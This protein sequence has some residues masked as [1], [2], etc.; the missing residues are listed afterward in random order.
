MTKKCDI[1]VNGVSSKL[2]LINLVSSFIQLYFHA[3]NSMQV[4]FYCLMHIM[5]SMW[6][7]LVLMHSCSALLTSG[8]SFWIWK[9][10]LLQSRRPR[11]DEL[12]FFFFLCIPPEMLRWI[13]FPWYNLLLVLVVW[14]SNL[15]LNAISTCVMKYYSKYRLLVQ[16]RFGIGSLLIWMSHRI[17]QRSG[18]SFTE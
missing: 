4:Y 2:T 10:E 12:F 16:Y 13:I 5:C 6:I 18:V 8:Q 14:S 11:T 7:F 9:Q 15:C 17:P 1:N 3:C